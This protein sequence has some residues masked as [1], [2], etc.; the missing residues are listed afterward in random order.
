[1]K[2]ADPHLALFVMYTGAS[3]SEGLVAGIESNA[4]PIVT[5]NQQPDF[6]RQWAKLVS[7]RAKKPCFY[8]GPASA[9]KNIDSILSFKESTDCLEECLRNM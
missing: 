6:A 4:D 3:I 2:S 8:D 5:M 7:A 1:M 9:E